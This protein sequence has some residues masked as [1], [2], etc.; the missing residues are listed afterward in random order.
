[1]FDHEGKYIDSVDEHRRESIKGALCRFETINP[2]EG[3][4]CD[5]ESIF[6]S[7][8]DT[9]RRAA[10]VSFFFLVLLGKTDFCSL[11]ELEDIY[12]RLQDGN[13]GYLIPTMRNLLSDMVP[14]IQGMPSDRVVEL[15]RD[16]SIDLIKFYNEDSPAPVKFVF[17]TNWTQT[18]GAV[19]ALVIDCL[20]I[21][22]SMSV[23]DTVSSA[24]PESVCGGVLRSTSENESGQVI[25]D[26]I[27]LNLD[28]LDATVTFIAFYACPCPKEDG[29]IAVAAPNESKHP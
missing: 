10:N 13:H 24:K 25:E 9:D 2:L 5:N 28:K 12:F 7:L 16:E 18:E 15:R 20:L 1:M 27:Q 22:E 19:N 17:V 21:N 4:A 23:V 14:D 3:F 26:A 6:F 11:Q 29:T 8:V